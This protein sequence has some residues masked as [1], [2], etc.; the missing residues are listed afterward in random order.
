MNK[1]KKSISRR[2]DVA[3]IYVHIPFCVKKCAYCD[4]FSITDLSYSDNFIEALMHEMSLIRKDSLQFDTLYI[5]GGTPS[6]LGVRPVNQIIRAVHQFFEMLADIEITMEINPGTVNLDRLKGYHD[7]GI[8]R[9]NIGVQ[10]FQLENLKFLGR[11]HSNREAK[12][13][14]KQARQAGFVNI[15]L[16]LIYGIPGQTPEA[17]L[18]D[19]KT[20]TDMEPDHISCYMLTY[21]PA[22]PLA[23]NLQNGR[24]RPMPEDLVADLF[25]ITITFLNDAGY[26]HYE[27]SNFERSTSG[28]S[29]S[30]RSRHNQKYWLLAP[31]LGFGPSA[32]SF[33]EPVRWWN[34]RSV[35]KYIQQLK[36]GRLPLEDREKLSSEQ[37]MLEAIYLGLRQADGIDING[38]H[39]KFGVNFINKFEKAIAD[40]KKERLIT[41]TPSRC[42]L[43]RK[44]MLFL[45]TVASMFL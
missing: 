26:I 44:G 8:N 4:F 29:E 21:E 41:I 24:F 36:A 22:T 25:A 13:A 39:R 30:K 11:L 14:I 16:D 1:M 40:L 23:R 3:G 43:T 18:D 7:A 31:Y 38:F 10:S 45:D 34:C 2:E 28:E 20:A 6:L 37:H 17:W 15:G 42:G 9:L 35:N 12:T 32:H 19:L 33:I 5:G 27:I